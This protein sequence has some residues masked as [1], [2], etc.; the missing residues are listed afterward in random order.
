MNLSRTG[1]KGMWISEFRSIPMFIRAGAGL[2][3]DCYMQD[4]R[5]GDAATT[6]SGATSLGLSTST[7]RNLIPPTAVGIAVGGTTLTNV[8]GG[9]A[10]WAVLEAPGADD[11]EVPV[12]FDGH[13]TAFVIDATAS[14][15]VGDGLSPDTNKNLSGSS[16]TASTRI[17]ARAEEAATTPTTRALKEV[18]LSGLGW[19]CIGVTF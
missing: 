6:T 2:R 7:W 3:G 12:V 10:A 19:L 5:K 17:V 8:G 16:Q 11:T 15:A 18:C 13:C 4:F 9:G 1:G 14:I